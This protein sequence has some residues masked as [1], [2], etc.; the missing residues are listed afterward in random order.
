[1]KYS[2][3]GTTERYNEEA[4]YICFMKFLDE[5]EKGILV[6]I[7]IPCIKKNKDKFSSHSK[8][9]KQCNLQCFVVYH[10]F[11]NLHPVYI[12]QS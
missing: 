7:I 1:M 5:C 12:N 10:L 9:F 4:T 3:K 2:E 6:K 8:Y 11:A